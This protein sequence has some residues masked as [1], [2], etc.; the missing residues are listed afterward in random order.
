MARK[1]ML[2][3]GGTYHK[4]KKQY[5]TVGGL[6]RKVKKGFVTIGGTYRPYFTGGELAYYGTIAG[7]SLNTHDMAAASVGNYALFGGG[8]VNGLGPVNKVTACSKSLTIS[9]PTG[10]NTSLNELSATS[11]GNYAVFGGG[12]YDGSAQNEINAYDA[13]LTR[14][15]P[16]TLGIAAYDLAAATVG[17]YAIFAGGKNPSNN[18]GLTYVTAFDSSFTKQELYSNQHLSVKRYE[19]AGASF[20]EFALFGG[21]Y[22]SAVVDCYNTSLTMSNPADLSSKRYRLSAAS[23]GDKY[24]LFAGGYE[25][26]SY[27]YANA[28]TVDA[29]DKSM[30][31]SNPTNLTVARRWLGGTS[32]DQYA[33]FAGGTGGDTSVDAYDANLTKTAQTSLSDSVTQATC[34]TVGDYAIVGGYSDYLTAYV[35]A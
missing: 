20:G 16:N 23:C 11:F 6:Y 21:G 26:Q 24:C 8:S 5:L 9:F 29:Y 13:S 31:H 19:L 1:A 3:V 12:Y 10:L 15:N 17:N 34:A 33:L 14:T 28:S 18:N 2:T 27:K 25:F 32:I 22:G 35:V 4:V 30:T 7:S